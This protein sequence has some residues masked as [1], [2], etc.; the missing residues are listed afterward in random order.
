MS[1]F[2]FEQVDDTLHCFD[3]LQLEHQT[4]ASK[5]KS[6]TFHDACDLL[7]CFSPI[8]YLNVTSQVHKSFDSFVALFG[9]STKNM[10]KD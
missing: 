7:V 6:K 2:P 3:G 9:G 4:V 10:S 1:E 8:S 5:T